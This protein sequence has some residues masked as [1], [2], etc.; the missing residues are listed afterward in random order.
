MAKRG[1]NEE[2]VFQS[3][4]LKCIKVDD[5]QARTTIYRVG[6]EC[7]KF[8]EAGF[9]VTTTDNDRFWTGRGVIEKQAKSATFYDKEEKLTKTDLN[10]LF[11]A[12]SAS[13]IWTAQFFKHEKDAAWEEDL[14][15]KIQ[16]MEKSDAVK[17]VKKH[18]ETFGKVERQLTGLKLL[19]S[20]INN[21]YTV[22][23]LE[24][25]F[26]ALTEGVDVE[27]AQKNSI[28]KLDVNSLQYLI[29]NSVKYILK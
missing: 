19:P 9:Q 22:R 15:T 1:F 3:K 21:Y 26:E 18:H 13:D 28:R 25:Y 27:I 23:D 8:G 5:I 4:K 24:N 14:V 17:F 7:A 6:R 16:G 10:K 2:E 29:F 12:L 20:S 11:A